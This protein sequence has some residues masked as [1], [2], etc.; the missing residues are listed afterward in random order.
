MSEK[1]FMEKICSAKVD[2]HMNITQ[3]TPQLQNKANTT[4]YINQKI[5]QSKTIDN[6]IKDMY[7]SSNQLVQKV[8]WSTGQLCFK[9]NVTKGAQSKIHCLLFQ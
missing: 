9:P 1:L 2:S 6:I 5:K 4:N 3:K 7:A 8:L